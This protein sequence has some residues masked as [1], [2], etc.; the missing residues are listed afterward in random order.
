MKIGLAQISPIKGNINRNIELHKEFIFLA[1]KKGVSAI[2]FPEL[3]ITG[4][5]PE[6]ADIL[7]VCTND[8]RFGLFQTISNDN[9]ITIGIGVPVNFEDGVKISMLIFEPENKLITYSKQIL[10]DDEKPYFKEGTHQILLKSDENIIA[11]A[12]CYESLQIEHLEKSIDEG[13]NIYLASVAKS[14]KGIDKAK[15]Y[16]SKVSK[17]KSIPILMANCVGYCDNFESVGQSSIWNRKGNIIG[18]LNECE[19]GILVY[20]TV[21]ETTYKIEKET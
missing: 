14:Q 8:N 17:E 12:I 1:I 20:D 2:F 9:K 6:L 19:E 18:Q 10:H 15:A 21:T 4:Y 5:E 3:S 7:K 11:P 13:A 16:Y